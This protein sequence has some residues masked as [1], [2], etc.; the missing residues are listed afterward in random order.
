MKN[1]QLIYTVCIYP[2]YISWP[3][4]KCEHTK[5]WFIEGYFYVSSCCFLDQLLLFLSL[6]FNLITVPLIVHFLWVVMCE[7]V[8]VIVYTMWCCIDD[9]LIL[10]W[11]IISCKMIAILLYLTYVLLMRVWLP[12]YLYFIG[13][14]IH[15]SVKARGEVVLSTVQGISSSPLRKT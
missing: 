1:Y 5:T 10:D 8:Y 13:K 6:L 11:M 12:C 15:D 9:E 14:G 2:G 3:V 7:M 4:C